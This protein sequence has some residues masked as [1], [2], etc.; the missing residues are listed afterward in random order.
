[1]RNNRFKISNSQSATRTMKFHSEK[2]SFAAFHWTKD[3]FSLVGNDRTG[4]YFIFP[5]GAND[6]NRFEICRRRRFC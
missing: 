5:S 6:Q 3:I 1:M 4:K 2:S